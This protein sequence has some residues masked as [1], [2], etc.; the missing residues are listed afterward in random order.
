MAAADRLINQ[1][2]ND[3]PKNR[4]DQTVRIRMKIRI[5]HTARREAFDDAQL[6]NPKQN[7]SRP[8]VV[9][10]LNSNEQPK[11]GFCFVLFCMQKQRCN[12]QQTFSA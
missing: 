11:A 3:A 8:D 6:F 2:S 7:Q 5:E 1:R 9:E 10:K 12:A 4:R